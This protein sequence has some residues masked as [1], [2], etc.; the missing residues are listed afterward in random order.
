MTYGYVYVAQ[1][2]MG[3]D[4]SQLLKALKEAE[5]YH[6]PSLVI[7]YAPCINHGIN[8]SKA[9]NE[10]KRAVAAGYWQ[11]YRFNP[12]A[13]EGTNR[14]TLDSKEPTADYK[15]FIMGETRYAALAKQFPDIAAQLFEKA[16]E[17]A[18]ARYAQ[19]KKMAE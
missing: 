15:E 17:E 4:Q 10:Q 11:L 14:F 16:A 8:M 2:C 6:G 1:V 3:A 19:Y 12:D 7:A 18:K 13:P 9:Q 5:A